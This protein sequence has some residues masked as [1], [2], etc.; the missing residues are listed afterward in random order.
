M[1]IEYH[2]AAPVA[3]V[4]YKHHRAAIVDLGHP[5]Y[6]ALCALA[7]REP[8]IPFLV[9]RYWP[10]TWAFAVQP[11]NASAHRIFAGD[12][13]LSEREYVTALHRLRALTVQQLVLRHLNTE[14][15]PA[16]RSA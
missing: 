2:L 9:A 15:P 4:E 6:R 5:T 10:G 1:L 8:A 7:D 3:L 12:V 14:R 11:V 13:Y 16:S